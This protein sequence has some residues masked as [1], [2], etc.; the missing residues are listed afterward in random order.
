MLWL[1]KSVL[2]NLN[3]LASNKAIYYILYHILSCMTCPNWQYHTPFFSILPMILVQYWYSVK[4]PHLLAFQPSTVVFVEVYLASVVLLHCASFIMLAIP[5]SSRSRLCRWSGSG[6]VVL[7]TFRSVNHLANDMPWNIS[8]PH[9]LFIFVIITL[10]QTINI[11]IPILH[12]EYYILFILL[13]KFCK[14][15]AFL[16]NQST[17]IWNLKKVNIPWRPADQSHDLFGNLVLLR[18]ETLTSQ[19]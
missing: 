19:E 8:A 12:F 6:L 13:P 1:F 14:L 4:V 18:T 15:F 5:W 11:I 3:Q 7:S 17:F 10:S 2:N 16:L 9:S